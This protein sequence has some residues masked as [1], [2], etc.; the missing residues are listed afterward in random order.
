MTPPDRATI[1]LQLLEAIEELG[2]TGIV[3][4]DATSMLDSLDVV[5]LVLFIENQHV[6]GRG[7]QPSLDDEKYMKLADF[8]EVADE[9]QRDLKEF[10]IT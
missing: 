9:L 4:T 7:H 2:Y 1:E 8:V 5:E 3:I 6:N 10:Y